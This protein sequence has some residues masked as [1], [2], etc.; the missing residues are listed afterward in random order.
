[1]GPGERNG[2]PP[3]RA[4]A[5][6]RGAEGKGCSRAPACRRQY[7]DLCGARRGG[8]GRR[9]A[10]ARSTSS[11]R[12]FLSGSC[13]L[14]LDPRYYRCNSTVG[15]EQIWGAYEVPLIGNDPPR[16]AAWGWCDR[17]YPRAQI[18]SPV[19]VPHGAGAFRG[20][21]ARGA[22]ARRTHR[23]YA[24]HA[25]GLERTLSARSDQDLDM[26]LRRGAADPDLPVLA[27][28]DTSSVWCSRCITTRHNA[29]QWPGGTAGPRGSCAASRSTVAT[30]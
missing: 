15:I 14:W 29:P 13:S 5:R 28:A 9:Q 23:L 3:I 4:G 12:G 8:P 6:D 16:T 17:D 25:P 20:I 2:V 19:S 18:V 26:V 21:A 27:D 10:A 24:S 11:R 7:A 30:R 22:L 1:M